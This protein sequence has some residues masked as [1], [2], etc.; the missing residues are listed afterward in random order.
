MQTGHRGGL[1]QTNLLN[2]VGF[3]SCVRFREGSEKKEK[4]LRPS[5]NDT[6]RIC[7]VLFPPALIIP[8]S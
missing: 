2:W 6:Y 8:L 7:N 4:V 3:F 5:S 1:H